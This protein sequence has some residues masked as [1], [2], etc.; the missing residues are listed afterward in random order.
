MSTSTHSHFRLTRQVVTLAKYSYGDGLGNTYV[1]SM[2]LARARALTKSEAQARV[3]E[4]VPGA[5]VTGVSV[6]SST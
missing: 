1:D 2:R 6:E 3:R 4:F 5:K